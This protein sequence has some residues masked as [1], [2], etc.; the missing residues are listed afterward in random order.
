VTVFA[1]LESGRRRLAGQ[2]AQPIYRSGYLLVINSTV[3]AVFG[4]GFWFLAARLYTPAVV[5]VNTT[6]V[7]TMMLIAGIAQL[8]LMSSLLRFV[9][10]AGGQAG[11]LIR[12]SYAVGGTV[13]A[14]AALVF[15]IGV[16][17]WSPAL[18]PF[19]HHAS[20]ALSFVVVCVCW[21]VMVMQASAMVALGKTA[22]STLVNQ[23]FN[24][25]KLLLLAAFVALLPETGVWFAWVTGTAVAVGIGGWYVARRAMGDFLSTPLQVPEYSP[26]LRELVRFAAPDYVAALAWI[27]CTSVVPILVLNLTDADHAAVFALT[28]SMCITLYGV[29]AALGQS[30]VAYGVRDPDRMREHHRRILLS[31]LGLLTPVVVVLVVFAHWV[32]ALFGPWYASQGTATLQLLAL[33]TLPSAVNSL[34]VSR[35][36]VDRQMVLVMVLMVSLCL[37]VLGLTWW[38]VPGAGIIGAA[39][40]WLVGQSAVAV[41]IGARTITERSTIRLPST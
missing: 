6:M 34:R 18:G 27:A 29:P 3:S 31:C 2:W 22:A 8:N 25:L 26:S 9:P 4:M 21:T 24:F 30:L 23:V 7:S 36:R 37:L 16:D 28:W 39:F 10:T 1:G 12:L 41:G 13:S 15:L 35:A 20:T 17:T 32:L 14:L 38:L 5:G 33:S 40:A 19:L 11:R